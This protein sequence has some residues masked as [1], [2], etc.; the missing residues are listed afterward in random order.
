MAE[1]VELWDRRREPRISNRTKEG[2][3]RAPVR[4]KH[5][6][7]LV[8][9]DEYAI[10]GPPCGY[11]MDAKAGDV[12]R[13]ERH[14]APAFRRL[15]RDDGKGPR[16]RIANAVDR[17]PNVHNAGFEVQSLDPPLQR[18]GLSQT[19]PGAEKQREERPPEASP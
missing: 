14:E 16:R 18:Q 15:R 11:P 19:Q 10:G 5:P 8:G 6:P 17:A 9:E 7:I 13:A 3:S 2:V 12:R 1:V 4:R